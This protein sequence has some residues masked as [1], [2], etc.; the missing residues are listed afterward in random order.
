MCVGLGVLHCKTRNMVICRFTQKHLCEGP[1]VYDVYT[2]N[3]YAKYKWLVYKAST[4]I[5]HLKAYIYARFG[6][7]EI[8]TLCVRFESNMRENGQNV[9]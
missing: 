4:Y 8:K 7:L 2:D 6:C 1:Y 3:L 9:C 5:I